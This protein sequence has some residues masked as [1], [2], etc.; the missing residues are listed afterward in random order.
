[1][2]MQ[3]NRKESGKTT[4]RAKPIWKW[5][6]S[7]SRGK[8]KASSTPRDHSRKVAILRRIAHLSRTL[9]RNKDA[10]QEPDCKKECFETTASHYK[11]RADRELDCHLTPNERRTQNSRFEIP[12]ISVYTY[13]QIN[14]L[15][16]VASWRSIK[17]WVSLTVHTKCK[18][19]NELEACSIM[20]T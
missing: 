17:K 10:I 18:S 13:I 11:S 4:Q 8:T 3:N 14:S 2:R 16:I 1:M 7:V 5:A 9:R 12:P 20:D 15:V 19:V 6:Q